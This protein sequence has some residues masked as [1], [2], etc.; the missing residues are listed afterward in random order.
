VRLVESGDPEESLEGAMRR[1]NRLLAVLV[2]FPATVVGVA[3][4]A[5]RASDPGVQ[6]GDPGARAPLAGLT[7]GQS[8]VLSYEV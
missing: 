7:A 8:L 6:G 1:M 3:H 5:F 4:A 2:L